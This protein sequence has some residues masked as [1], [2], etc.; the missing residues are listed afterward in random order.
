[1]PFGLSAS[2]VFLSTR[3]RAVINRPIVFIDAPARIMTPMTPPVENSR[4]KLIA[5]ALAI[6]FFPLFT[7]ALALDP[8]RAL[9]QSL[10]RIAQGHHGLPQGTICSILQTT[11][12]YLRLR[13]QN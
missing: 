12:G 3:F 11:D 13:P 5:V 8:A 10:H 9:T 2:T 1:M 6:Q 4:R 7:P